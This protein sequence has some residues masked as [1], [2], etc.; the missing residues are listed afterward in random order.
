DMKYYEIRRFVRVYAAIEDALFSMVSPERIK[1]VM[2]NDGKLHQ[3]CQPC[4]KKYIAAIEEGRL[5]YDKIKSDVI[6]SVY[7]GPSTQNLRHKKRGD[8]IPRYNALNLHSWFYR[9]TIEARMFDGTLDA[10]SIIKW[11]ILWAMIGDYVVGS[12]D[13]QVAKD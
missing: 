1:G 10:D 12:T 3:Y 13:E 5:P 11:G 7:A 2:D 4:G 8:G 9:G 6:T